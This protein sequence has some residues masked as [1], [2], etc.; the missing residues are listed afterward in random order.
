MLFV[1]EKF[2]LRY[3][4]HTLFVLLFQQKDQEKQS[5]RRD[6]F[7]ILLVRRKFPYAL[8][9]D[10][11][12]NSNV[13]C[14]STRPK[15]PDM[16]RCQPWVLLSSH[17][18]CWGRAKCEVRLTGGYICSQFPLPF[19]ITRRWVPSASW[20]L[21]TVFVQCLIASEKVHY[22]SSRCL[23]GLRAAFT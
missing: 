18:P 1:W 8:H 10:G 20:N 3:H 4:F 16:S 22:K 19:T 6:I 12:A 23:P 17:S 2:S 13:L 7:L 9:S 15:C 11:S 5:A 14:N 21:Q